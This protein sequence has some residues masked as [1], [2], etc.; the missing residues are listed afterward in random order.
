MY[1]RKSNSLNSVD[2]WRE[3]AGEVRV[4]VDGMRDAYA[5]ATLQDIARKYELL[6]ELVRAEDLLKS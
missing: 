1:M 6:A 4:L 3:R 5:K 2:F